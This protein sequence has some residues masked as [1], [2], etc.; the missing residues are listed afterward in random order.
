MDEMATESLPP[1]QAQRI[2]E[3][4]LF[5]LRLGF[6]AFGGPAAHIAMMHAEVVEKRKWLDE[7]HFLDLLG[8]ANIIPGPTSTELAIFIGFNRAGWIGLIL[9]GACFILPAMLIVLT[10]A[11][12]YVRF[13]T[14]PQA[15]WLF[16]GIKPVIIAIILQALWSLGRRAVKNVAT[17]A[18]GLAVLVLYLLGVNVLVLLAAGGIVLLAAEGIRHPRKIPPSVAWFPPALLNL[19]VAI[20]AIPY[21][22][23]LLFL[24]FLKIGAVLYGSGYVLLAFLR[25]DFVV[26]LGWLTDQQLV[27]AIAIGQV[28]PGPVFTTATFIGYLLGGL[29][30]ALLG[31]L[32]IFLP[33]FA[34]VPLIYPVLNRLRNSPWMAVV[35]DGVI[36]ASLGLMAGVTYQLSMT[37][38]IDPFTVI[39]AIVAAVVLLR[40]RINATW[41][42]LAGAL[43]GVAVKLLH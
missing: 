24:T 8:G 12:I 31:T 13:G 41:L 42:I 9:G 16:Y 5:F 40:F 25:A 18:V 32:G 3:V 28:T 34:F 36:M 20:S 38:M 33:S 39:L 23:P 11:W 10:L 7:Q 14:T 43:A 37:A 17:A 30:G 6:T 19:P 35:L 1:S 4:A 27:D 15:S 26:R 2:R 21:S 29:P 22:L